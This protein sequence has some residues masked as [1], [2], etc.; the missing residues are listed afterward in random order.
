MSVLH[1]QLLNRLME[2]MQLGSR[3]R[4]ANNITTV[5]YYALDARE[6][7]KDIAGTLAAMIE[8]ANLD[9]S[10]QKTRIDQLASNGTAASDGELIDIRVGA[11]GQSYTTAGQA[12]RNQILNYRDVFSGTTAPNTGYTKIWI[13]TNKSSEADYFMV[14]EVKD[15]T[16]NSTDTWSS[17]KIQ[18]VINALTKD[19]AIS[20]STPASEAKLWIDTTKTTTADFFMVPEIKDDQVNATD[21]WSSSKIRNEIDNANTDVQ[22]GTSPTSATKVVIDTSPKTE[23]DYFMLPEIKDDTVNS[24]DTWSS[25]KIQSVLN[26]LTKDVYIGGT[27]P[28]GDMTKIWIDTSNPQDSFWLPQINDEIVSQVDTWSSSK[29]KAEFTAIRRELGLTV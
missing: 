25:H 17:S 14:P 6:K 9:L 15:D 29:I 2:N 23:A 16:V 13:D 10:T 8:Q 21:T 26:A 24:T 27:D 22:I 1:S 12:V 19:V 7:N 5:G 18:A 20:D 28:S 4:S 3:I 11:D